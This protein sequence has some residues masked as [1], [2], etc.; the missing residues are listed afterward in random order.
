[1]SKYYAN[2]GQ[3]LG[4][5]RCCN[6]K[7]QGTPGPRGIQGNDGPTGATGPSQIA[8]T[9]PTGPSKNFIIEHPIDSSKYLVHACLE[10][11]EAGVYYRGKAEIINNESVTIEVPNY[12]STLADDFNIQITP[13]YKNKI[14]SL[15]VSEMISNS[16]SVY[17]ENSKFYWVVYGKRFDID[18]EPIKTNVNVKGDG[19]YLYI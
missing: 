16:F 1:M 17:G 4:A 13:I 19:P 15:N 8:Y 10:G 3:Y 18:V 9:G 5:Q 2:Y 6:S 12:V 14:I 11:P 7:N